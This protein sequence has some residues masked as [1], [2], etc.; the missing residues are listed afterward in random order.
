MIFKLISKKRNKETSYYK[1]LSNLGKSTLSFHIIFTR[2][3]QANYN[4]QNNSF[5]SNA[6][7]TVPRGWIE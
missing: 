1:L 7:P 5:A 6:L 2:N 4:P 3:D